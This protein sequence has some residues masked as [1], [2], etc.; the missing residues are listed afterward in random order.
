MDPDDI[1]TPDE[2]GRVGLPGQAERAAEVQA[3]MDRA[4]DPNDPYTGEHEDGRGED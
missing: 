1:N 2:N 4:K 3:L